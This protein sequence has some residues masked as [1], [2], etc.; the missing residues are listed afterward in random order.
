MFARAV[1]V[2][3]VPQSPVQPP[4]TLPAPDGVPATRSVHWFRP[5]L[6]LTLRFVGLV[7][8]SWPSVRVQVVPVSLV[9]TPDQ[10][11]KC[12]PSFGMAVTL[13]GLPHNALAVAGE[14][15]PP[16][17]A[18]AVSWHRASGVKVAVTGTLRWLALVLTTQVPVPLQPPP[19]QLVNW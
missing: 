7:S 13:S 11:V 14:T 4:L 10:P 3:S 15:R 17:P 1:T 18:V 16:C 2:R 5:K 12:Q 19:L 6:A 8:R 9:H